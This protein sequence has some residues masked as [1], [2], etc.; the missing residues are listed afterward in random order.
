MYTFSG[1]SF[2]G[3]STTFLFKFHNF[4]SNFIILKNFFYLFGFGLS[5]TLQ[6][7]V[8]CISLC[9]PSDT[10]CFVTFRFFAVI[11]IVMVHDVSVILLSDFFTFLIV[12]IPNFEFVGFL[13]FV[14]EML[15][16]LSW[17]IYTPKI[18]HSWFKRILRRKITIIPDSHH[19]SLCSS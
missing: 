16:S 15:V 9:I 5:C 19:Q 10:F 7:F 2:Y 11:D 17:L 8:T 13:V 1:P 18:Y 4:T 12:G 3:T 6:R 14:R